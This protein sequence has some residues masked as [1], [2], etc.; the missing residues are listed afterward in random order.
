[1]SN[2]KMLAGFTMVVAVL[3]TLS[4]TAMAAPSIAYTNIIVTTTPPASITGTVQ[5]ITL[6]TDINNV[7]SVVVTLTDPSMSLQ[8]VTLS[9]DEAIKLGLVTLDAAQVPSENSLMIG[10]SITVDPL[11]PS[12]ETAE[13]QVGAMIA[14]FFGLDYA[15]V[16]GFHQEGAG[17]GVISQAC[18]MSYELQSDASLC[19]DI[20]AAKKSGDY[21]M[22]TLPDGTTASNWGQFKQ[23][24]SGHKNPMQNLGAIM[25]GRADPLETPAPTPTDVPTPDP[26]AVPATFEQ[27]GGSANGNNGNGVSAGGNSNH[28]NGNGNSSHSNR[29]SAGGSKGNP[30]GP[31]K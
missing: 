3:I 23:I 6:Q 9:L 27:P 15:V 18:W 17:Y 28:G 12:A 19:A 25:S 16:D 2:F 4:G 24:F 11:V 26:S 5:S 14:A 20:I 1:M 31:K 13:N 29:N 22:L 30:K 21:S 8:T 10:Q 7:V